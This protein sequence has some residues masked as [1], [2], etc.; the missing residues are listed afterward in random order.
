MAMAVP[1]HNLIDQRIAQSSLAPVP[2]AA[3]QFTNAVAQGVFIDNPWPTINV[4][5]MGRPTGPGS[6]AVTVSKTTVDG[7]AFQAVLSAKELA[8]LGW[9]A[10]RPPAAEVDRAYLSWGAERAR[11]RPFYA[12]CDGFAC[13]TIAMLV[14]SRNGLPAGTTVEWFGMYSGGMSATGHAITVVDRAPGSVPA[15]PATWGN[16]CVVVDQWYALQA[17]GNPSIHVNGAAANA[18]YVNWLTSPGNTLRLMATFTAGAYNWLQV[19]TI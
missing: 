3:P 4:T 5:G 11:R 18:G 6:S 16:N 1:L 12:V 17:G 9:S 2:P 8:A 14:A 13:A 19:P 7:K 15:N 10:G